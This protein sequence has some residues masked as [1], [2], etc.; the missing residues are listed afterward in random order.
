[1]K[2]E[3]FILVGLVIS[4]LLNAFLFLRGE[5][6]Q[7]SS[8]ENDL[9]SRIEK[10][11]YIS[12][13]ILA[14]IPND[15]LINFVDLRYELRSTVAPYRDEFGLYFE[16]LPTG[17]SIGVNEKDD[18]NA[19][20]LLKV[21]IVM[22]NLL[23]EEEIGDENMPD[24][25]ILT[26]EMLNSKFGTLWQKGAGTEITRND[27]I[28]YALE[29]SDNTAINAL[30]SITDFKY[31][32]DVHNGL[33]VAIQDIEDTPVITLKGYSSILQALFFASIVNVEHS[34]EILA[35]LVN[36]R[37][38]DKLAAGVPSDVP[39]ANKIG[40]V[41]GELYTDC[42]IVYVPRRQYLLCMLSVSDEKTAQERMKAVSEMVY[43]YVANANPNLPSAAFE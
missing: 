25:I 4:L 36:S 21:P 15:Y 1:M 24:R 19:A 2:R 8:Q 3:K 23:Q 38:K 35:Y 30:L 17:S 18:F 27:A 7:S 41:D 43:D 20:S 26:E 10:Y 16:Y 28:R 12:K 37:F 29:D 11:P 39:V 9:Q 42:G 14:E 40:V 31:Y 5:N 34:Q 33:D 22:G 6:A 32:E 13:R